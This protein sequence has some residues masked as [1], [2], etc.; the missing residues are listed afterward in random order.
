[1]IYVVTATLPSRY[2]D[3][4]CHPRV[5]ATERRGYGEQL[6]RVRVVNDNALASSGVYFRSRGI[7]QHANSW[8]SLSPVLV[9]KSEKN[10]CD[11]FKHG[12]DPFVANHHTTNCFLILAEDDIPKRNH[13]SDFVFENGVATKRRSYWATFGVPA[14][15]TLYVFDWDVHSECI[16]S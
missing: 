6:V 8:C 13:F 3:Q 12:A 2:H 7:Q 15:C 16:R 14:Q 9:G 11:I 1:M 5:D 4:K 10:L